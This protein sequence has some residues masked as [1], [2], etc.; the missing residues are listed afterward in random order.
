MDTHGG[1]MREY[2]D[3]E[4]ADLIKKVNEETGRQATRTFDFVKILF[5]KMREEEAK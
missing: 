2:T 1:R 3:G 5:R 4:I